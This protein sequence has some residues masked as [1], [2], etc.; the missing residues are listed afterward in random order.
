MWMPTQGAPVAAF[1]RTS[2]P[3][4]KRWF[5]VLALVVGLAALGDAMDSDSQTARQAVGTTASETSGSVRS[6]TTTAAFRQSTIAAPL[7]TS[8]VGGSGWSE[9]DVEYQLAVIDIGGFVSYDDPAIDLYASA[10]NALEPKCI[11]D[12]RL[13][14]DQSVKAVQLLADQGVRS[15][16]LEMLWAAHEA[17]PL[18]LGETECA[19]I[20]AVLLTLMIG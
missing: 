18:E 6:P 9:S 16:T 11:E 12:R 3:S 8:T 1:G 14:A 19:G 2:R 13:I 17:I 15:S 10:L 20:F 4:I 7:P 5:I